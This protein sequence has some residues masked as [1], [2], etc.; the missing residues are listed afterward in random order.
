MKYNDFIGIDVSKK[1]LDI[2]VH[3]SKAH[4][5]VAN[6]PTGRAKLLKALER[7]N[8]VWKDVLF[9]FENTGI[10]SIPLLMFL[11]DHK[12]NYVQVSGLE[13]KRSMGIKRGKSDRVD[14]A[15]LAEL[16]Y[17]NREKITLTPAP[18]KLLAQAK[19]VF[20]LRELLVKQRAA[21]KSRSSEEVSM[22]GLS[23]KDEL[24]RLQLGMIKSLSKKIE[25]LDKKLLDLI[26]LEPSLQ[27]NYDLATSVK[28]IGPQ[29]AIYMLITT[30]NFTLFKD[31]R[32]YACY[33]GIVPFE[34]SSGT[35]I[36]RGRR[37]SQMANKRIKTLLSN[38]A[39]S[40]I[41]SNPELK[42]YFSLKSHLL[43]G[44]LCPEG[45]A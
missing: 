37:V 18:N 45:Y 4:F 3:G 17:T 2:A 27:E 39:A 38:A 12:A 6:T 26:A 42:I 7:Q 34:H 41:Q 21:F 20:S 8:V 32:K 30:E 44:W 14:A 36:H 29:T 23:S 43:W 19:R 1:T 11:A 28:G 33:S 13:A 9:C 31:W 10:Y 15:A 35:S 22:L 5:V 25:F 40:A 24:V 16:A